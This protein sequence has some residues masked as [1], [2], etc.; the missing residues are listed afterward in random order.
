MKSLEFFDVP[1][2]KPQQRPGLAAMVPRGF[3]QPC[4]FGEFD[5]ARLQRGLRQHY[6]DAGWMMMTGL[7]P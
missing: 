4:L 6:S 2:Q 5:A 1:T 7:L 3:A